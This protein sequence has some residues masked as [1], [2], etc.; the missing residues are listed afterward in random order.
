MQP[1]GLADLHTL[2]APYAERN[3]V[4]FVYSARWTDD[5][6]LSLIYTLCIVQFQ[7]WRHCCAG[8]ACYEKCPFREVYFTSLPCGL[9]SPKGNAV[10]RTYLLAGHAQDAFA[11]LRAISIAFDCAHTAAFN[12]QAAACA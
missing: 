7:E 10:F 11:C 4:F 12:T 2:A 6:S 8:Q 1:I 5:G 3:E 9:F